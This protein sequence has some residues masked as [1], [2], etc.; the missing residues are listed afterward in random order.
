MARALVEQRKLSGLP[1]EENDYQE[2][3]K[4]V[5][6]LRSPRTCSYRRMQS[7]QAGMRECFGLLAKLLMRCFRFF[8][9]LGEFLASES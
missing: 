5:A 8:P 9:N 4:I 2:T 6:K 3:I 1:H 7:N